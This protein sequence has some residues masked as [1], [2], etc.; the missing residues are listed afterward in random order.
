MK[1][2]VLD[3]FKKLA[4][5]N[6]EAFRKKTADK[7]F[8]SIANKKVE[9]AVLAGFVN[10]RRLDILKEITAVADTVKYSH[11]KSVEKGVFYPSIL[12]KTIS[13][14]LRTASKLYKSPIHKSKYCAY[15]FKYNELLM[16]EYVED[17][18]NPIYNFVFNIGDRCY[19]FMLETSASYGDIN[20]Y[21]EVLGQFGLEKYTYAHYV[22]KKD[23]EA[24]AQDD[25]IFSKF[26]I[27]FYKYSEGG[28][29]LYVDYF[30]SFMSY[31]NR[32]FESVKRYKFFLGKDALPV[33][34]ELVPLNKNDPLYVPPLQVPAKKEDPVFD[35]FECKI[36]DN[37]VKRA[38]SPELPSV[39]SD[40]VPEKF[41][42]FIKENINAFEAADI[43][44]E[45]YIGIVRKALEAEP[46]AE[47][48]YKYRRELYTAMK[49]RADTVK[50]S[51]YTHVQKGLYFPSILNKLLI[52][53]LHLPKRLYNKPPEK[54]DYC[55]YYYCKN[56]LLGVE[57][58][59]NGKS[60]SICF[61]FNM[62][63]KCYSFKLALDDNDGIVY[64]GEEIFGEHGLIRYSEIQCYEKFKRPTNNEIGDS[65]KR[66][67]ELNLEFYKY[68]GNRLESVRHFYS[69][70][71]YKKSRLNAGKTYRF[72]VDEKENIRL[73]F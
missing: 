42:D 19:T 34:A 61:V 53:N 59:K 43:N 17:D 36:D 67:T 65:K 72:T 35:F 38:L 52:S 37:M 62:Y 30:S 16:V 4:F 71:P 15:Y 45:S 21:E 28:K 55:I 44:P 3:E 26:D 31:N 54:S 2:T 47:F 25:H 41:G 11:L 49:D 14:D 60:A 9:L 23:E 56:E 8:E 39:T 73:I 10:N 40:T 70:T 64:V 1:D 29:L 24:L 51:N 46:I 58:I 20:V 6:I 22:I 50:Y 66:L 27:E 48:A 33:V 12:N 69:F 13:P 68:N 32:L 57:S 63:D 18:W 7:T 5:G